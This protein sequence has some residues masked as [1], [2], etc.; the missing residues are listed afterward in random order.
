M[1]AYNSN[2]L[3]LKE[4]AAVAAEAL[5]LIG[6]GGFSGLKLR[7]GRDRLRDDLATIEAVRD[8]VRDDVQLMI[9]FSQGLDFAEALQ[10]CHLI[11]GL[12]RAWIEAPIVYDNLDGYVRPPQNSTADPDR[13]EL[14]RTARPAAAECLRSRDA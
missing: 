8:A 1:K 2:G 5:E 3:W 9:D 6:E 11:D 10:R 4:P 13:G 7:L 14:L 12:D